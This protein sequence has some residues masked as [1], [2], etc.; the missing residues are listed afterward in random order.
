MKSLKRILAIVLIAGTGYGVYYINSL[1]PIATGYAAKYM[2]SAVFV[3]GRNAADVEALDL[4]FSLIRFVSNTIDTTKKEVTSSLLWGKSVAVFRPDLGCTLLR[5]DSTEKLFQE[6][7]SRP[8][9]EPGYDTL[10]WPMGNRMPSFNENQDLIKVGNSLFDSSDYGGN[11]FALFITKNGE[12]V[13]ERYASQFNASTRFLS[14]SMAKSF[15]AALAGMMEMDGKWRTDDPAGIPEWNN[16]ARSRITIKQLLH[17]Q[18]GLEWNEDYGNRSDVTMMLY[19]EP[20]FAGYAINRPLNHEPGSYWYYS[21]GST[22]IVTRAMCYHFDNMIDY[23]SYPALRLFGPIGAP[24]AIFETDASGNLAGSSYIFATARDYARFAQLFLN[25]GVFGNRQ[26]LPAEWVDF[27]KSP[28]QASKGEY[29]AGFWLNLAGKY[30][31]A[32]RSMYYCNG[33]DG[34]RIF[35]LPDE[36]ISIVVLGYSP[37]PS[38]VMDFNRLISDILKAIG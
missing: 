14:W 9:A 38:G 6:T 25:K 3:S 24:D 10:M 12:P 4:N 27:C 18:S 32:P 13:Y 23:L 5:G 29:G 22:N 2:A 1:L 30:P 31:L 37:K 19:C 35:I 17:M 21:S 26:L 11:A 34:Q 7:V 28:A 8:E 36:Q 16:D 20:D 15:T 33:H